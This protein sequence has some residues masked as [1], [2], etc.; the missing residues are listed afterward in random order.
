MDR[1][2]L[3]RLTCGPQER[4]GSTF[5]ATL[6]LALEI[7]REGREGRS[8]GTLFTIGRAD[9]VLASA[10]PLILDP[11]AA[12][13]RTKREITDPNLRGTIKQLAELD[14]AFVVADDGIVEGACR[15]LDVSTEGVEVSL[16]LG[17][18]HVTG[19]AVSKHLDVVAIAVSE[20]GVVRVFRRGECIAT[21]SAVD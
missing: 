9:A 21:L 19:A 18:R 11:L 14:G 10:R 6:D 4:R 5:D 15:Y 2:T 16:G 17:S 20:T 12:H 3:R 13:D 1:A 8:V 7:A